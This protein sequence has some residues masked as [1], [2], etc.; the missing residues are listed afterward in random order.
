MSLGLVG[1]WINVN[2]KRLAA[3]GPEIGSLGRVRNNQKFHFLVVVVTQIRFNKILFV[4]FNFNSRWKAWFCKISSAGNFL[5]FW[6]NEYQNVRITVGWKIEGKDTKLVYK[7]LKFRRNCRKIECR[8][9]SVE[10]VSSALFDGAAWYCSDW[11]CS[12]VQLELVALSFR[13]ESHDRRYHV[14]QYT[15]TRI[16]G[17]EGQVLWPWHQLQGCG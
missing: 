5:F 3:N 9:V 17:N 6:A 14:S 16:G 12:S 2:L 13:G 1:I 10:T 11:P 8:F 7:A 15:S 4:E